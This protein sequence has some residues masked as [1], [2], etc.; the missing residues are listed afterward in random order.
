MDFGDLIN[1][2]GGMTAISS[3]TRAVF[4]GGRTPSEISDINFVTI[5][6]TGDAKDFGDL[7]ST[8][9][10]AASVSNGHGGL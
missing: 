3:S 8:V 2:V 7:L 1:A 9:S 10:N 4:N 5:A 6:S